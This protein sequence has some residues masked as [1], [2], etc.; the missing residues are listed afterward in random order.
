MVTV[1]PLSVAGMV[2]GLPPLGGVG[3]DAGRTRQRERSRP[4]LGDGGRGGQVGQRK[5]RAADRGAGDGGSDG[6]AAV[7]VGSAEGEAAHVADA[8]LADRQRRIGAALPVGLDAGQQ[9]LCTGYECLIRQAALRAVAQ[10][11]IVDAAPVVPVHPHQ[12]AGRGAHH[13]GGGIQRVIRGVAERKRRKPAQYSAVGGG[14]RI[15]GAEL[16][17]QIDLGPV[18]VRQREVIRAS[19]R[20]LE[21]GVH[22]ASLP[23]LAVGAGGGCPCRRRGVVAQPIL[24]CAARLGREIQAG[25]RHGGVDV[26]RVGGKELQVGHSGR[27][28]KILVTGAARHVARRQTGLPLEV[29]GDNAVLES[30][31]CLNRSQAETQQGEPSEER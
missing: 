5:G 28:W 17:G 7:A 14:A 15:A 27:V 30:C 11:K 31:L 3:V 8:G 25:N 2:A 22:D 4:G 1:L 29:V 26:G 24:L 18:V 9:K 6:L 10:P 13:E 21:Q 12:I 16:S 19:R 23:A 20:K